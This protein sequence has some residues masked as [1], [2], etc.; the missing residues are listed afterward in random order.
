MQK[1][2]ICMVHKVFMMPSMGYLRIYIV[3]QRIK[4]EWN[5]NIKMF[6]VCKGQCCMW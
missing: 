2:A 3:S 6:N 5:C 1:H 4:M